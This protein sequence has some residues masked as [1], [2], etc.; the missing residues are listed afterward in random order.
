MISHQTGTRKCLFVSQARNQNTALIVAVDAS[1]S[2]V[3]STAL[4]PTEPNADLLRA[5]TEF[6]ESLDE[7]TKIHVP[8]EPAA[9][10]F[11][12]GGIR[13]FPLAETARAV[14]RDSGSTVEFLRAQARLMRVAKAASKRLL[15]VE[16]A[17]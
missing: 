16:E 12:G 4:K 10:A 7:S 5:V 2:V 8:S 6:G 17:G 13:L 14:L 3:F 11:S 1:G 9:K 15:Q